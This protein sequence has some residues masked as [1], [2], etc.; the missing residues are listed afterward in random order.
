[1][2]AL[3]SLLPSIPYPPEQEGS[4]SPV[5]STID[6]C[7]E[8]CQVEFTCQRSYPNILVELR[9][10]KVLCGDHQ[11]AYKSPV[12]VPGI[13]RHSELFEART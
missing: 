1:M 7:E 12:H 8:V 2:A 5:T 9:R 11:H 10:N 3:L 6:W 13:Q 4:W